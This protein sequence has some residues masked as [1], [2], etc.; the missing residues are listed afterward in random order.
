VK[1]DFEG[2]IAA[3]VEDLSARTARFVVAA[4]A[5]P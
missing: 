2:D 5:R 4:V 3:Y 1:A